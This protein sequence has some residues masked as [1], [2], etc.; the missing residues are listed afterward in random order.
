[1]TGKLIALFIALLTFALASANPP[2]PSE[3]EKALTKALN[4]H[5]KA[6]QGF[7]QGV[8]KATTEPGTDGDSAVAK[9][10][11][12]YEAYRAATDELVDA[13]LD[14]VPPKELKKVHKALLISKI[15]LADGLEEQMA[16]FRSKDPDQMKS[17]EKHLNAMGVAAVNELRKQVEAAGYDFVRFAKDNVLVKK[18]GQG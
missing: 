9:L 3:Y 12:V 8:E 7:Y 2:A 18:A 10:I 4:L 14:V 17:A 16:A 15:R 13:I 1:M 5:D 6:S 11:P